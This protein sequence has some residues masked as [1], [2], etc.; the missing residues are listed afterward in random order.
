MA[1]AV[2]NFFIEQGSDFSITFQYLNENG[3][4][5]DLTNACI[6]LR[7][8]T[9]NNDGGIF[10]NGLVDG[11]K[12]TLYNEYGYSLSG[13]S[14]GLIS[15]KLSSSLTAKY[16]FTTSTYDLDV[17]F[18]LSDGAGGTRVSNE[19]ISTGTIG[20][21]KKNFIAISSCDISSSD[22]LVSPTPTPSPTGPTPTPTP[23]PTIGQLDLCF[24]ECGLLD[25]MSIV[26]HG[27]GIN[28]LDNS[29]ATISTISG[30]SD[31]RLIENVEIAI[32][33]LTHNYPQDLTFILAP[34]SG[35]K[36]LLSANNKISNYTSN[37]SFMFSNKASADIY[38]NNVM[39]GG[40]CNILDKTPHVKYNNGESLL[41]SF[42]HLFG[43][44]SSGDWSLYALDTDIM[45][46]GS[47]ASWKLIVTYIEQ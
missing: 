29:N 36:I 16:S 46:S 10:T 38:L 21:V 31:T 22:P 34:P 24:P 6:K 28:I 12:P 1:A 17:Q 14:F 37:F 25:I 11:N 2:Y 40:Y 47:I 41:A 7:Y 45:G 30:V 35:D 26:Y 8:I 19:R 42:D 23:T 27:S 13:D 18:E 43:S 44:S 3:I 9:N 39:N 33:G 32:N 5:V 4:G 15:L 20:I